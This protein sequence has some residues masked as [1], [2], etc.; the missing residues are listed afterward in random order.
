VTFDAALRAGVEGEFREESRVCQL[1][2]RRRK[3][4]EAKYQGDAP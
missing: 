3:A 4:S 2:L 1:N